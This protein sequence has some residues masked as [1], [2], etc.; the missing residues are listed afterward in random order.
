MPIVLNTL[1]EWKLACPKSVVG[2]VFP[3][4]KGNVANITNLHRTVLG[5]LQLVAGITDIADP[6]TATEA[7]RQGGCLLRP[8]PSKIRLS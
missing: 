6:C 2:L 4:T 8:T 3:T 7:E 5:P 1:K